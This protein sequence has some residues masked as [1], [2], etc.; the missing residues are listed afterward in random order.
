[1]TGGVTDTTQNDFTT[2]GGFNNTRPPLSP[3]KP[4]ADQDARSQTLPY[5]WHANVNSSHSSAQRT[6]QVAEQQRNFSLTV[7]E[8][9]DH[10]TRSA[11]HHGCEALE[12]TIQEASGMKDRSE[13]T[14]D[15]V[16]HEVAAL[17][18]ETGR[19]NHLYDKLKDPVHV[20]ELCVQ[21]RQGRP[22]G[23]QVRDSVEASLNEVA[24][25]P[26]HGR[27]MIENYLNG[28]DRDLTQLRAIRETLNDDVEQKARAVDI[29][30]AA[31]NLNDGWTPP[32]GLAQ[33]K[34]PHRQQQWRS[35][36]DHLN[37]DAARA[38][39]NAQRLREKSGAYRM[40]LVTTEHTVRE[41]LTVTVLP[42]KLDTLQQQISGLDAEVAS[43]VQSQGK[44][45]E[46]RRAVEE[47]IQDM[48]KPLSLA[49]SRL[50]VR[51]SK[52]SAEHVRDHAERMLQQ[53]VTDY[54][55]AVQRLH[56]EVARIQ[57]ECDKLDQERMRLVK[58][59]AD[60]AVSYTHLRAHE[61]VLDLVCRLLLEKKKKNKIQDRYHICTYYM[62]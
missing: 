34:S 45:E 31:L 12:R 53:E 62:K 50:Q 43:V 55:V 42:E 3:F 57:K 40:E 17:E 61:T 39:T 48:V 54:E 46:A 49:Q 60:K 14:F 25:C 28:I 1:M 9:T 44:L 38:C 36:S 8:T 35:N 11:T 23:E 26:K 58:E 59:R 16:C 18:E 13:S 30:T 29:D 51:Q 10:Q 41:H 47:S 33:L 15:M 21:V 27:R 24:A 5:E 20:S 7:K 22:Q 6:Q 19:L 2:P 32:A 52:P 4:V 56:M 37:T